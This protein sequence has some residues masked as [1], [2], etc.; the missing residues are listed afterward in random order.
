MSFKWFYA[1]KSNNDFI[2]RDP[3]Y[4]NFLNLINGKKIELDCRL[5]IFG[6]LFLINGI[7]TGLY[8]DSI[9]NIIMLFGVMILMKKYETKRLL[10]FLLYILFIYIILT[11]VYIF[12]KPQYVLEY[13]II[14]GKVFKRRVYTNIHYSG[15]AINLLLMYFISE[16]DKKKKIIKYIVILLL[17]W[18]GKLSPLLTLILIESLFFLKVDKIILKNK[19]FLKITVI[20]FTSLPFIMNYFYETLNDNLLRLFTNRDLLLRR[21]L[22]IYQSFSP[23]EKLIGLGDVEYNVASFTY[24][25]HNQYMHIILM[26]GFI[27]FLMFL[28]MNLKIVDNIQK[29]NKNKSIFFKLFLSILLIMTSDDYHIFTLFTIIQLLYYKTYCKA[30]RTIKD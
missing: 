18:L 3:F 5:F 4:S 8:I 10:N 6:G 25:P 26:Y 13:K 17:L 23:F 24:H 1:N 19:Y 16:V 11:L 14:F 12:L 22:E 20:I 30:I 27:G 21:S 29:M 15:F 2:I 28:L 7:Y 9:R